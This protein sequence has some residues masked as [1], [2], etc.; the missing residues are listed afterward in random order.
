MT[1]SSS[2]NDLNNNL[3][4]NA[5]PN[6]A[7]SNPA[8]NGKSLNEHKLLN[9]LLSK[10]LAATHN[11]T[12]QN[13]QPNTN[14]NTYNNS[15]NSLLM[16]SNVNAS[17][18]H[19]LKMNNKLNSQRSSSLTTTGN[20]SNLP[21]GNKQQQQHYEDMLSY[22]KSNS[23]ILSLIGQQQQQQSKVHQ[24]PPKDALFAGNS[25]HLGSTSSS[26][27]SMEANMLEFILGEIES[28]VENKESVDRLRLMITQ[29]HAYFNEKLNELQSNRSK[30]VAEF[31][32]VFF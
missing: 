26:I 5:V 1:S 17:L 3:M 22:S 24:S 9:G 18:E 14:G 10:P 11:S 16:P 7:P 29:M 30:L 25:R 20:I 2:L 4:K 31:D 12:G 6:T 15:H 28:C 23:S 13:E 19:I 8:S 27:S 32:E 21:G